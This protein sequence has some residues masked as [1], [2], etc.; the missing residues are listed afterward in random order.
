MKQA[1]D[2]SQF[3]HPLVRELAWVVGS[4]PLMLDHGY[5]DVYQTL[6]QAWFDEVFLEGQDWFDTLEKNA[7]QLESVYEEFRNDLLGKRFEQ[8]WNFFFEQ[9]PRFEI[10][11]SNEQLRGQKSTLGEIDLVIQDQLR[12]E[13]YHLELACKFYLSAGNSP[14][15]KYWIGP[16]G[17]DVLEHKM[18]KLVKQLKITD[19]PLAQELLQQR[20]IQRPK[21]ILLMKGGFFHHLPDI[22]RVKTPKY[23]THN[24]PSGW[25]VFMKELRLI[26]ANR[27]RWRVLQKDSWLCPQRTADE[28]KLLNSHQLEEYLKDH[29]S[30]G[31]RPIVVAQLLPQ[32]DGYE[33]I[34]RGF[35][36]PDN[37]LFTSHFRS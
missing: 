22:P 6:D 32:D 21:P 24:Y 26:L 23:A 35:V 4:A 7:E 15:W 30:R 13:V 18:N 31:K 5:K 37:G 16:G 9:N 27:G 12:G 34:G 20:H 11:L 14:L 29:F 36:L 28:T 33:E 17:K 8:W 1:L 25:W 3:K 19:H 2:I 10:L